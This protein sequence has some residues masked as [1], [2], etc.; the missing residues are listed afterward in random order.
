M[1]AMKARLLRLERSAGELL[2]HQCCP[3]CKGRE[4]LAFS[5]EPD[6]VGP[7]LTREGTCRL[8]HMPP[9]GI[10]VLQL[11]ASMA[12]SFAGQAWSDDP[13]RRF[14]EKLMLFKAIGVQDELAAE[15][16]VRTLHE[17]HAD[18]LRQ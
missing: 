15:Q 6:N 3:C 5:D 7:Q 10:K 1:A 18:R 9:P 14:M 2:P 17:R 4:V 11:P 12:E 8:C 13:V 16:A